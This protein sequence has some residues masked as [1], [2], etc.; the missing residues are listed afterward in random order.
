M[1][2]IVSEGLKERACFEFGTVESQAFQW[3]PLSWVRAF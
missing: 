1:N 2:V 3:L